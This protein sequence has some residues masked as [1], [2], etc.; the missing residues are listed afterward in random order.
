MTRKFMSAI[1]LVG[2]GALILHGDS[3]E[4]LPPGAYVTTIT[5]ADVPPQFPPEAVPLLV[6]T[7]EIEFTTAGISVTRKD[8]ASV[9]SGHYV[10][11]PSRLILHDEAGP[12]AC[13]DPGTVTGVYEWAFE[14]GQL[15][16]TE[17]HDSCAGRSVVLTSHGWQKQ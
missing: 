15:N 6:G 16:L 17:I 7:W 11:N 8:G 1:T 9:V 14:N 3:S 10:S 5:E 2:L 12:L 4:R 13:V